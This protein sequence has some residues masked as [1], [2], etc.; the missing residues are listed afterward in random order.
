[1]KHIFR[2][3]NQ[4]LLAKVI[5][6]FLL[7][8]LSISVKAQTEIATA[9]NYLTANAA[10]E[11]LSAADIA[12]MSVSS[13]YLS[14]TTG[15]YHLYFNQT[16][17]LVEVYNGLMSVT[18]NNGQ[19]GYVGN[20][21]VSNLDSRVPAGL[22][23]TKISPL[24]ALE[25]AAASVN[26]ISISA[27]EINKTFLPNGIINKVSYLDPSISNEKIDVKLYWLPYE[28]AEGEKTNLKVALTW[29]VRI[30]TKDGKNIWNT[31][32]DALSGNILKTLDD[33]IHCNFG[34]PEHHKTPH[35]CLDSENPTPS[36]SKA[37]LGNTYNVFDYPLEAPTFGARTVVTSPYTKFVATG[38]GPGTTN[39]WHDD[40]TTSFTNTK[41][42]NV[43]AKDDLAAD[44]EVT[45][46]SSPNSATLDFNFPYSQTTGSAATNLNSSITNIFYWNNVMHDI[47]WK[48]GFDEPGG[49]FQK[50]NLSRGGVGNDFVFA[51]AQDG[52]GTNNANFS[53]PPDG[54]N[55]RMQMFIF[56][57]AGSPAYQPDSDFDNGVI[58]HEYGH[59]W[60]I[61]LT[62]GPAIVNCLQNAE[63]AG[64]GWSDYAAL[65]TSTNW[66]TL[67]P[68]IASA[69]IPRGIGTYVL[70]QATTGAGIR[71]FRYSYDKTNVNNIVTYAGVGNSGVFSQPH[72][73][74]S[75]WA[76]MLWDMTWEIILQDNFIAANI[77]DVPAAIADYR[78]NIAAM[79]LVNEG[80]RLQPCSPSFVQA[81]DAILQA[82]QM[83]FAGRYRCSIGKA[84]ARRGLGAFASTGASSSDRVVTEDFTPLSGPNLSSPLSATVCSNNSFTYTA[85][86]A[87]AGSF[88]FAWT[89][90]AVAG[91]SNPAASATSANINET[92]IN[93]TNA[94]VTVIY[95]F[96][97]SPD[98]CGGTPAQQSVAV[99]VNPTITPTVAA[100]TVCQNASVPSGEGLAVA[101]V[102]LTTTVNGTI[103]SGATYVRGAGDNAVTYTASRPVF[104]K[105]YTFVAPASGAVTFA[106]TAAVLSSGDDDTYLTLYQNSFNPASP[107]TNFLR[108]DDDSG[109]GFLSS[110]TQTLTAGTTYIVVVST[111]E[112]G[113]TGTFTLQSSTA[114]FG[115][116]VNWYLNA[117]GGSPLATGSVF[118]PVGVA[119][120]G[121]PNTST[122][123]STTFYVA[124]ALYPDC[125]TATV[126]TIGSSV[127]GTVTT[128]ATVC[129]GSN[130]GTLTLTGHTGTILR[131]ESSIDNFVTIVTIANT[132]TTQN[133]L[134]LTQTIKYRAVV[135][136]GTCIEAN[137]SPATIT[138]TSGTVAGS[139]TADATVCTGSNAGTLTLAGH[140]GSILRWESS[141][142]NFVTIVVIA[143]TT[144]TQNYLNLTQTIKYRA[145]VQN[146]TCTATNS[147]PATITV[148]SGT[149]AG[150]VTADATVCSGSNAGTLTL[151]GHT[152]TILRWESSI[153]NFVTI[154]VIANTTTTQNYLNLTQTIKYRA[155][156]QNGT[157]TAA[158]SSPA[159]IT[160]TNGTVAGSVTADATVCISGNAGT[161]TLAGHTGTVLRWESSI[162][163]FVT[164]VIIANTTTT[165]NYLN[166]TQTI[167]YRAVVQNGTCT[168][169]NSSPATIT[170]NP[171][172]IVTA[173][174]DQTICVGSSA[175]LTATCV[176]QTVATTLSGAS[177]V[178]ANASTATG[179]ATGT[180]NPMTNQLNLT[181]SF[182]GLTAS[183]SAGHIHN[184]AVGVNGGVIIGFVGVPASTS[185]TFNYSGVLTAVQATALLA[186]NTYVNIHNASFPGGEVRGQLSVACVANTYVWNP[187]GLSGQTVSVSPSLTTTYTVTASN[188][189][190]TCSSTATTTVTVLTPTAPVATGASILLGGSATLTATGCTGSGF[191]LK[192][193][194][195]ADNVEVTM[196]VSPIVTTQY[197]AKCEQT[198]GTTVCLSAKS[199]DAILT[200][201]IPSSGV[202]VYVNVANI[203]API[204]NGSSWATAY[205][206]LQ[207]ALASAPTGSEIWVAQGTYKPTN[208]S[209]KTISFNIPSGVMVYGGFVGTEV[210]Q[211]QRNFTTNETILSGEIGSVA[212]IQDN[213]FHVVF[214]DGAS[215]VTR[216]DG[217]TVRDGNSNYTPPSVIVYP[218]SS[219]LPVSNNDGGG[220]ALDNG[221]SPTI[222]NCKILNNKAIIG[223]G[224]FATNSSTPSVINCTIM[225]NESTFGGGVYHLSSNGDYKNV[226]IAGNKAI[227]GGMY[228]NISSPTL[229]N[230]TIAGNGGNNG[231]I[232][233]SAS[234]PTVKNSILWGNIGPFNDTQSTIT[235]SIV[236]G[237]YTGI[238]NS[239]LNPQLVSISPFGLSPNV[240]GDYQLTNTSPAIDAGDNGTI[241]LTDKDL[242]GSLRRYNGGVVDMGAYEFQGVRI[243]ATVISIV[244]GNWESNS[245][246]DIGRSPLAGDNVIINNN[247]NVTILNTGTAKNVE[248]RTNAKIIHN[249]AS[250]KLQTGI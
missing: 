177:E 178:P 244:S 118:N 172:P 93:T 84:F 24:Q 239:N 69:N 89:R 97:I 139:V 200:V 34:T 136:N 107:A 165:Q 63:Q 188:S 210:S 206:N 119:G 88:V 229:T 186:G 159:T 231:S 123:G 4:G 241:T 246:W 16:H 115:Q 202:I 61:R 99:T 29:N 130:S 173:S 62:G 87:T 197:Y 155:V 109:L 138:V 175:S 78:G 128:N 161:L 149:V 45:A 201:I 106:T 52:S 125:R 14:P 221:S 203:A 90:A 42:N 220:I 148:T 174:A 48:Y 228:N 145:V 98:A 44:N 245:T 198:V 156:V 224:I 117:S 3:K 7:A 236:E 222:A 47:L 182:N 191:V 38:T 82:D 167:K 27:S 223:A 80:L 179:S 41:G 121:I 95:L 111:F 10:K 91:I 219:V 166:L 60:S 68:T 199:N 213:S 232:F 96:T 28:V 101:S 116:T 209:V 17:Q 49:N 55:G 218:S 187:G 66:S 153:D 189:T 176:L 154:V 230:V 242:I 30:T 216:L 124:D 134:N 196:P 5:F 227:G 207:T 114:V 180:F 104:Y 1:M 71:P 19:V 13:A 144:T 73:I 249:T 169:A 6:A 158:N 168:E 26:L 83:L 21:F 100:Y 25:K 185:G 108:G 193:Y 113:A 54:G 79:K 160:V 72:G 120:S 70:G 233:N 151:A 211:N 127:G 20:S 37:L 53:T 2:I 85:T 46:G 234:S 143:N 103:V 31:H 56:S 39:G 237:G 225:G 204:Q 122:L 23:S 215:N 162:D 43:D 51:D 12:E 248:I 35:V 11:K 50:N 57:N 92:L 195:T 194:Q 164:I 226:L 33:V 65:M 214:F 184:A 94:P 141:I 18:L 59:G 126:F 129:T 32:V 240:S 81:R 8:F 171:V 137:S 67:T 243:G 58:A 86:T 247:H 64:E 150:S 140:T 77:Y 181:V 74:G 36:N 235:Y 112:T 212:N 133:Y 76:T 110:L 142:D 105:T 40:G 250:S 146:G 9:K 75:I 205:G 238:G 170:V 102:P 217:F 163:N 132:T 157:C 152:G 208:T 131:W 183:A 192:W 15:W 22:I 135:Q 190:S 147:S